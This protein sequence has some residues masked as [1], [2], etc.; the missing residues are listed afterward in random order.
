[1][2]SIITHS[3][4][5][6]AAV[7]ALISPALAEGAADPQQANGFAQLIP[8]LLIMVIFYF[9]LIR[10]QQK[11]VKEH[12]NIIEALKKGD[13][14]ITGGGFY[15]TI[16]DVKDDFLKVEIAENVRVKIKRDTIVGLSD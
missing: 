10:P 8:L 15:G 5:A 1:M 16:V 13:K 4:A 6:I 7:A 3:F 2:K 12:R 11:K 9:L 14:V